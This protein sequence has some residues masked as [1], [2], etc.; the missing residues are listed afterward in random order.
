MTSIPLRSFDT[1]SLHCVQ[2]SNYISITWFD[3][4]I[5]V[6]SDFTYDLLADGISHIFCFIIYFR[7]ALITEIWLR[8]LVVVLGLI[9]SYV[10]CITDGLSEK[11]WIISDSCILYYIIDDLINDLFIQS[12]VD[13]YK[14]IRFIYFNIISIMLYSSIDIW[15]STSALTAAQRWTHFLQARMRLWE[16]FLTSVDN[17]TK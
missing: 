13:L 16:S 14:S 6:A 5:Y 1:G 2:W 11:I 3:Q 10:H 9:S 12:Q 7:F 15:H 8:N 4:A 17:F